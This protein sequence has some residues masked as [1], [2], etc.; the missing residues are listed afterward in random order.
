M[1]PL[2]R[3]RLRDSAPP[4]LRAQSSLGDDRGCA[5]PRRVFTPGEMEE[6]WETSMHAAMTQND[7][8]SANCEAAHLLIYRLF[9]NSCC[10]RSAGHA[11][12]ICHELCCSEML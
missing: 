4:S 5:S 2:L 7:T 1:F 10:K 11:C 8:F 6:K 12:G 9:I 3:V